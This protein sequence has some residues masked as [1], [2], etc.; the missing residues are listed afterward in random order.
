M[1]K[2]TPAGVTFGGVQFTEKLARLTDDL[3]KSQVARDAGLSPTAISDYLQKGYIPRIDNALALAR[4]LKV[5]L[6]W[7]ADNDQDWPPPTSPGAPLSTVSDRDLM[8]EAC[9]RYLVAA[10]D[11]RQKLEAVAR[12]NWAEVAKG[13]LGVPLD[14]PMANEWS[15]EHRLI[16]A[17]EHARTDARRF[18]AS[19]EISNHMN[20]SR[21]ERDGIQPENLSELAKDLREQLPALRVAIDANDLRFVSE[22]ARRH[23]DADRGAAAEKHR[24]KLLADLAAIPRSKPSRATAKT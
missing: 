24:Q 7:L 9:R 19:H 8:T 13:I 17:L 22:V 10:T 11:V 21:V 14:Q 12:T 18:D 5:P 20:L 4:A 16:S 1:S 15:P 3:N 23:G 6:D 2:G